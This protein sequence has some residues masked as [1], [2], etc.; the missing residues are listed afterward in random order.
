M[1]AESD[2]GQALFQTILI[3]HKVAQ[4]YGDVPAKTSGSL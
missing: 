3:P 4:P 2:K 1:F